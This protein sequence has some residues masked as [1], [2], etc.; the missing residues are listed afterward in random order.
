MPTVA[1]AP[2]HFGNAAVDRVLSSAQFI[3]THSSDVFVPKDGVHRA[4]TQIL[5]RMQQVGYSTA[6]WKKHALTPSTA[7]AAAIEWIFIVDA[8]NFSFW[9]AATV[10]QKEMPNRQYSVTLEDGQTYRGYWTLCAAVNRAQSEGIPI[11]DARYWISASDAELEHVFRG[12]AGTEAMPMLGDRIR[13]LRE[14]GG[15]LVEKYQGRFANM[16]ESAQGSARRLVDLVVSEFACFRD[17][18]E[19]QGRPVAM[20]KRA[21]ILVADIWACFEGKGL[22]HFEDIDCVTMFADYRVPQA[23]CHFGALEYSPRLMQ[24]LRESERAVVEVGEKR[25]A[26]RVPPVPGLLPSG[27]QW[28]MEI[29]GNSIWAVELIRQHIERESGTRVSAILID[30]YLWDYSKEFAK[31]MAE[32]PIHLTRSTN[33]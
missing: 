13:V 30:F 21:Q 31:E 1:A 20:Y 22:G 25:A 27:H 33:Y 8:L 3:N 11:T 17:E 9:S 14:V 29:R 10:S 16:L 6:D 32:I 19:C 18:H 4:G 26:G 24:Y 12:D 2:R 7:N 23:L 5:A 15:V 28:E